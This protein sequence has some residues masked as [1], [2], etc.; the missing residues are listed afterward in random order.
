[1][2]STTSPGTASAATTPLEGSPAGGDPTFPALHIRPP[3]GWVNDP[4][5]VAL[6]D[7]V[8]HVFFQHNPDSPLHDAI[9]WGHVS[10]PDLLHWQEEP[11]A[12]VPRP[13][14]P[15]RHGC[16]TG[17]VV[18]DAGVPTAVYSAVAD[19]SGRSEVVLARSDRSLRTWVQDRRA[20]VGMPDDTSITDVR[21]PFVFTFEGSRY[22]IQ[23]AGSRGGTPRV[24]LYGCDDLTR[25]TELG[26]LL[27]GEHPVAAEHAAADIWE[28]PNLVEVDGH[29]VLVLSLWRWVEGRHALSGVRYLLGDL[30]PDGRGLRFEPTS[31]GTLDDGPAFYAPQLLAAPGRTLLWAWSWELGRS[32]E[33]I[34]RAGW[35]GVLTFPRELRVVDGR[36]VSLP[37]A[38]LVRLRREELDWRVDEGFRAGAFEVTGTAGVQL[39]LAD[40]GREV[41]VAETA[42]TGAADPGR[43][44]VDGSLVEVFAGPTPLTTRAYP[45]AT[46]RW[47][48]RTGDPAA[49]TVRRLGLR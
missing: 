28:C 3:R 41:L 12:L 44:L 11:L 48:V 22:A 45:T 21:D 9:R 2:T 37:A 6:V 23:G 15:D 30:V 32:E 43:L 4:N 7:G 14:G 42:P 18:D 1:M 19:T 24:L 46:S 10:S 17:C 25:W 33:Q 39:L 38:E 49:V 26:E 27:S 31:G 29:R 34:A 36:L 35:A 16:W 40:E 5:G 20:V 8:H 47:L 13:D